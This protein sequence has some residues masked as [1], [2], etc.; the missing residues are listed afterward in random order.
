[1]EAIKFAAT[2][3]VIIIL[4]LVWFNGISLCL[5][6]V[7]FHS[8]NCSKFIKLFDKNYLIKFYQLIY[9][10]LYY[11]FSTCNFLSHWIYRIYSIDRWV[12]MLFFGVILSKIIDRCLFFLFLLLFYQIFKVWWI[13]IIWIIIVFYVIYLNFHLKFFYLKWYFEVSF[14]IPIF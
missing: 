5:N 14:T 4:R 10:L 9:I 6:C 1:M 7:D 8:I 12:P 3:K 11:S 13:F 2:N